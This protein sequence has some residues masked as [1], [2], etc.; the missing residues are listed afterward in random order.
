[1]STARAVQELEE[2]ESELWAFRGLFLVGTLMTGMGIMNALN[3]ARTVVA[4]RRGVVRARQ[5]RSPRKAA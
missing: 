2:H 1:V 5:S 4:K 3:T